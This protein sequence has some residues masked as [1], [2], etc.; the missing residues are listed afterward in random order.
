MLPNPIPKLL[1]QIPEELTILDY[2]MLDELRAT[3]KHTTHIIV[4]NSYVLALLTHLQE[5]NLIGMHNI[6]SVE[7]THL[8]MVKNLYGRKNLN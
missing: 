1:E 3:I 4:S 8:Y 6:S 5:N 7:G 2:S